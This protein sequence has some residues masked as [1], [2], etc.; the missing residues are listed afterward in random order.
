MANGFFEVGE[1]VLFDRGCGS[2]PW[3]PIWSAWDFF[4]LSFCM[5]LKRKQ[6][7]Q[8]FSCLLVKKLGTTREDRATD[9]SWCPLTLDISHSTCGLL[10]SVTVSLVKHLSPS[11]GSPRC[12]SEQYVHFCICGVYGQLSCVEVSCVIKCQGVTQFY[13]Y[14]QNSRQ[15]KHY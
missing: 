1:D 12:F 3:M 13:T 7:G 11:N 14:C 5:C 8:C 6:D 15:K 4:F 10:F 2:D 9:E